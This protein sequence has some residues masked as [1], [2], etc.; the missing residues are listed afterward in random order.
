[1]KNA[2]AKD[3]YIELNAN[4]RHYGN[5]RFAQL[6][7]FL[8]IT[9][10]LVTC[11]FTFNLSE[12]AKLLFKIGGVIISVLFWIVDISDMYLWTKFIRR[13]AELEGSLNY[14][15]YSGLPGS[16]KFDRVRP[17]TLAIWCFYL[18]V[19]L[20]WLVT[21]IWYSQFGAVQKKLFA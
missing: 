14:K 5:I 17:A 11:V 20:F 19:F 13:A 10:G 4:L 16:P 18:L 12:P 2:E 8:A 9:A 15:Q 6:T 1:M 3:E 21:I 7:V